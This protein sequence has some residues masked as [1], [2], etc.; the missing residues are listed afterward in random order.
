MSS[1]WVRSLGVFFTGIW[2]ST[3]SAADV[4]V[5]GA[6]PPSGCPT[7]AWVEE[8]GIP[9]YDPLASP[10]TPREREQ[11]ERVDQQI[12]AAIEK[13]LSKRGWN[14][15][16]ANGSACRIRYSLLQGLELDVAPAGSGMVIPRS[17][18]TSSSTVPSGGTQTSMKRR[19]TFTFDVLAGTPPTQAWRGTLEQVL[20]SG[21][22][23]EGRIVKLA[24]EVVQKVPKH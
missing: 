23:I 24:R 4:T 7:Y 1:V 12:R 20:G 14:R 18:D 10:D 15:S 6:L 21:R 9:I 13:E 19:G 3:L 11:L 17:T 22:G 2:I 5:T 8:D 16:D